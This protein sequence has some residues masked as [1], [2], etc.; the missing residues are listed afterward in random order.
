MA[1]GRP[2]GPSTAHDTAVNTS[3]VN[4]GPVRTA[5]LHGACTVH[6]GN[7]KGAVAKLSAVRFSNQINVNQKTYS[8]LSLTVGEHVTSQ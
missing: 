7:V 1:T 2:H 5:R 8:D 6:T 3:N 4:R